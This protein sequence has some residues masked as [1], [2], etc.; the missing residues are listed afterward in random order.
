MS[1]IPQEMRDALKLN[2]KASVHETFED[3]L[4]PVEIDDSEAVDES[5][6]K[7]TDE[8][9]VEGDKSKHKDSK[10]SQKNEDSDDDESDSDDDSE[11]DDD[12]NSEDD[13]EESD[14]TD[15]VTEEDFFE[16]LS[17]T[18]VKSGGSG[19]ADTETMNISRMS[20][21]NRLARSGKYEYFTVRKRSGQ[22]DEY[23]VDKGKLVKM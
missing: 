13:D 6:D 1:N 19:K 21:L 7:T 5:D 8:P 17:V 22:E 3:K 18:A 4:N 10:K 2:I 20:Q 15:E 9:V 11:D 12:D 16:S 14:R 23:H